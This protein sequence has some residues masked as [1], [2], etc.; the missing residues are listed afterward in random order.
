MDA[1]K[2]VK[3][4]IEVDFKDHVAKV[5]ENNANVFIVDWKNANGSSTYYIRYILDKPTGTLV[6]QGDLGYAIASWN[7][8]KE[9]YEVVQHMNIAEYF[10]EKLQC[11]T[12]VYVYDEEDITEDLYTYLG[13]IIG[14][15][16][17]EEHKQIYKDFEFIEQEI[18][19]ARSN[20]EKYSVQLCEMLQKYDDNWECNYYLN[21]AG[22]RIA[23]R[24]YLWIVGLRMAYE[25]AF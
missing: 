2:I 19:Y 25:D 20:D 9:V 21:N 10:V 16:K 14:D 13:E 18:K 15:Y 22:E 11:S 12:D 17:P 1:S 4:A 6:I 5:I 7:F 23:P 3:Q 24:V 8:Y